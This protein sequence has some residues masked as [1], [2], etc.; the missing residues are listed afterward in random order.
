LQRILE[1][2]FAQKE[3]TAGSFFRRTGGLDLACLVV[4]KRAIN[5]K[6]RTAGGNNN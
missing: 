3:E 2:S 5:K 1:S 4:R 6:R